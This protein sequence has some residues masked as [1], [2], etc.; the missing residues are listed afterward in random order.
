MLFHHDH[1]NADTI[2]RKFGPHWIKDPGCQ[3]QPL[4]NIPTDNVVLDELYLMLR[5]TD[6]LEQG[7]ILEVIDWDEM[8]NFVLYYIKYWNRFA[9]QTIYAVFHLELKAT[10][11][12]IIPRET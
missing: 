5:V 10:C 1:Y 2:K 7:L 12:D 6:R 4:F 3:N 11:T 8:C 9:E